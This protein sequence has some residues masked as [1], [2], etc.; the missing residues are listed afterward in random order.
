[1]AFDF[2]FIVFVIKAILPFI[3]HLS[4]TDLLPDSIYMNNVIIFPCHS[5]ANYLL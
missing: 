1:M 3:I 2:I 4:N 5:S